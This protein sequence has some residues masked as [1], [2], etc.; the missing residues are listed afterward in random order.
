VGKGGRRP[1]VRL[2]AAVDK[3]KSLRFKELM[4]HKLVNQN[5]NSLFEAQGL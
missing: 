1:L 3:T 5:I 2:G 4:A